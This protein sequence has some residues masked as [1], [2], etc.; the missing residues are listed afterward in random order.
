MEKV[1]EV[2]VKVFQVEHSDKIWGA[3]DLE[4]GFYFVRDNPENIY[5]VENKGGLKYANCLST[6]NLIGN[7]IHEDFWQDNQERADKVLKEKAMKSDSAPFFEII[8]K[9]IDKIPNKE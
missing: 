6:D 2:I 1:K 8:N 5:T 4:D 9:L 7:S 3:D